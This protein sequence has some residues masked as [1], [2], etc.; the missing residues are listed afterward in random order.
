[1]NP[2]DV[3]SEI[4]AAYHSYLRS[5]FSPR[6]PDWRA[7]FERELAGELTLTKGPY[8]QATP[9][10]T[11]GCSLQDLIARGVLSSD[12][13]H[14]D[15]N[16]F[17]LDRRLH[18]HQQAAIERAL[19][20]H[21]LLIATGTGSGKT[22]AVIFPTM[23][24]LFREA[25]A[26][27]LSE[28]GV[29]AML[30]YPMN[31][32]A[33]DQ[34]RRLRAL[35]APFPQI[36]FGRYIGA[37]KESQ[38]AARAAFKAAFPGQAL[39]AN[40][41]LSR[42]EMRATPPHILLTNFSMLE[43]LLL[44]PE[45]TPFFDG[46][47]GS[48][49]RVVV[50]DEVHVYDGADGTEIAMLLRRLKDRIVRSERG[51][52]LCLATSA[53][54]GAG[55]ADYPRL[56]EYG[57][58]LF[59]EPFV[60]PDGRD[61]QP[62]QLR[63]DIIGP[64]RLNL[65]RTSAAYQIPL[66]AYARVRDAL[67]DRDTV[68]AIGGALLPFSPAAVSQ[69]GDA[70]EVGVALHR[71]LACDEH[72]IRLQNALEAEAQPLNEAARFTFG[73]ESVTGSLVALVELASR[74]RANENEAPLIP[75]RY[76]FW[77]RGLEGAFVC[78]HAEHPQSKPRLLLRAADDC[79]ACK[80]AGVTSRLFELAACRRCRAEY[81]IGV[82][83][84]GGL[85]KRAPIGVA[86]QK[87]LLLQAA[88]DEEDEDEDEAAQSVAEACVCPGCG[89]IAEDEQT[90]CQCADRPARR[91]AVLVR[92][93]DEDNILRRCAACTQTQQGGEIIGRFLTDTNAPA[94]IVATELYQQLPI[95][96]DP[97]IAQKLG[98]GRKLLAFAD[99]RAEA[100]F[101]APYL[102]RTYE[103]ALRRSLI[104]RAVRAQYET[105][106]EALR[107][108]DL[109]PWLVNTATNELVLNPSDS[110]ATRKTEI[111]TWLLRELLALD[112][113]LTLDGVGL[114]R[115]MPVLP[116]NATGPVAL[117]PLG[118]SNDDTRALAGLLLDT[119]RA[120]G[121]LSFPP[122]VDREGPAFAPRAVDAVMRG[123]GSEPRVHVHS[124][125]P[126]RGSNRRKDILLKVA[127]RQHVKIDAD[128]VLL[129]LWDELIE[130]GSPGSQLLVRSDD[131]RRGPVWRLSHQQYEFLPASV[132]GSRWQCNHCRQLWWT[133]VAGV[134]PTY[135]CAGTLEALAP[136]TVPTHYAE[137]YQRLAPI[138]MAVQEHTA[139]WSLD[140]G[141]TVQSQFL[142]GDINVLSC[143]TTFELGVDVGEVEAVLL[144]NVPPS[145][146]NY[147]QRAGRAGRRAGAAAMV[148]TLAQRR[149]HDL[150]WFR[151]PR[152][153]IEGVVTPPRI[154]LENHVIA[155]R[156]AHSVAFGAW[157]KTDP[158]KTAGQF[159]CA[160]DDGG[161]PGHERFI[162][163]LRTTP[164]EL[165]EALRRILPDAVAEQ[166]DIDA[167]GWVD[168][169]V[170]SSEEDPTTGWLERA[171][172]EATEDLKQLTSAMDD[173][174]RERNFP[175]AGLLQRQ[176]RTI[177]DEGVIN[178][179]ARK[180]VLPKYGFP[181]D[182]V[183]LDLT[184]AGDAAAGIEL[185]RDMRLAIADYAPGS[186]VVAG[187]MVWR[188]EGLK[189]HAKR[190]W[191]VRAWAECGEC[192][193]YRDAQKGNLP[194]VC[195]VCGSADISRGRS[196]V[197]IAPIFG[198][199]GAKSQTDIVE[200]PVARR[201]SMQ[202][203]FS[204]YGKGGEPAPVI[205]TGFA[206]GSL[207]THLS[208]QGR[209]VV[210]NSGSGRRGFRICDL[211]GWG[212]PAPR[213]ASKREA[214][215]HRNPRTK[216]EC[217]GTPQFRHLGHDFLTDVL[218]VRLAGLYNETQLRSALYAL[219][220]GAG[221]LGIKRDEIDGT[222]HTYAFGSAAAIVIYDTV[223]GGAG[224]AKRIQEGFTD[225]VDAALE[226]VRNCECGPE[227]SCYG[228]L[229]SYRNQ[230]HHDSL[231]R[232]AAEEAL[233]LLREQP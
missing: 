146:A 190:E 40:E 124:W 131:K 49:W 105:F 166:I 15:P 153:M 91:A 19:D 37:T 195:A 189:R 207:T 1:M 157:L 222:L 39:P 211:C 193:R 72:V 218:E 203:W 65:A 212:E 216:G 156:H 53:T 133:N 18:W 174:A 184:R 88:A 35:L 20:G 90:P 163:W 98:G 82:A 96:R 97:Q 172:T 132:A 162:G 168:D 73:D 26:G 126:T 22:E 45:D 161:L 149:N 176:I 67:R 24:L 160:P 129:G 231:S 205:P 188:S 164:T 122:N 167:W 175:L 123:T 220:E 228:C 186:E 9:P 103:N 198:F 127:V 113:R 221:R 185:E 200:S 101:F 2:L 31:A 8:L 42:D 87:Y 182:V 29:R 10:F 7:A 233:T 99:S 63:G 155:R 134:C 227:T 115:M 118:L 61:E 109:A 139:Q 210:V 230:L 225:V 158:V 204:E 86:P 192:G 214:K 54:L 102:E 215:A 13:A 94:S 107:F 79:A 197:W 71:M 121:V 77:L 50:L 208:R 224:H 130:S 199:V 47:T 84:T 143:S 150:S 232:G 219:L 93:D 147:V 104:F 34:L 171:V 128:V 194:E 148:L 187:K 11:P 5:T 178:F 23:E 202:S 159:V 27:T 112:R 145:P 179:L 217:K 41:L 81:L 95:A 108:N 12:F 16:V 209:I 64:S 70:T 33:N 51:R 141:T 223:P 17:P 43:Y 138:P 56:R 137:L 106:H 57:E 136:A 76:H 48:H 44:R 60:W 183:E 4:R 89:L 229:R 66:D 74:A 25:K 110:G 170:E 6:T 169:L 201:S 144:R 55:E 180:N 117:A 92:P 125:V 114:V 196:G 32:L 78:L 191:R 151:Q 213:H 173:A 21:N 30:L 181:V 83:S 36:T 3:S 154:L 80:D 28:P 46:A 75:A 38:S 14:L 206:P 85:L 142:A 135:R 111:D 140:R 100:A 59:E 120:S 226:R 69:I 68:A 116:T 152:D 177:T 165:R 52:L 62:G 119:M 58:A